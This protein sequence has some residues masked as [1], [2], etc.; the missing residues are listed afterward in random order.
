MFTLIKVNYCHND[1]VFMLLC[2]AILFF[3]MNHPDVGVRGSIC[4]KKKDGKIVIC[5]LLLTGEVDWL[6][7][8]HQG[9]VSLFS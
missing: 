5:V 1:D 2:A 7:Q 6:L 8:M 9:N 4:K 3:C